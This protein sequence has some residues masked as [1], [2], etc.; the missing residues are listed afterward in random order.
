MNPRSVASFLAGVEKI[1]QT[2][3]SANIGADKKQNTIRLLTAAAMKFDDLTK[4]ALPN[5]QVVKIAQYGAGDTQLMQK[6]L[7]IVKQGP[8]AISTSANQLRSAIDRIITT[9]TSQNQQPQGQ[10][11]QPPSNGTVRLQP[12]QPQA[13]QRPAR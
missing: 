4:Q 8:Q 12:Q 6:Y 7:D 3:P 10:Q 2:L 9:S 1:S 11:S 13:I 5:P